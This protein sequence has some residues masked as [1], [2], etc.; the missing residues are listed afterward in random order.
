[1][2]AI[3]GKQETPPAAVPTSP[4]LAPPPD[5]VIPVKPLVPAVPMGTVT[6]FSIAGALMWKKLF[7]TVAGFGLAAGNVCA[8]A[9]EPD[10]GNPANSP[11]TRNRVFPALRGTRSAPP[12]RLTSLEEEG[13]RGSVFSVP[14]YVPPNIAPRAVAGPGRI[15]PASGQTAQPSLGVLPDV[16]AREA[17]PALPVAPPTMMPGMSV[18]NPIPSGRVDVFDPVVCPSPEEF[19]HGPAVYSS[20]WAVWGSAELLLGATRSVR[21]PPV[22]TTGPAS[23]GLFNAGALGQPGTAPLFGGQRMLGNW[24]AG[25]RSEMG[26]WLDDDHKW[27]VSGRF[28]SLFSTSDQLTGGSDGSSVVNLPQFVPVLGTTIQFPAYVGFPGITTG[29]VYASTQTNFAG[30]D[31]SLRRALMQ[32]QRFRLDVLAGYRQL[33]L[34]DEIGDHFTVVGSQVAPA[35]APTLTGDDSLR[36]RNNFFGGQL[37]GVG[38]V[39][40]KRWT[41]ETTTA[42]AL[43]VNVSDLDFS[44]TRLASVGVIGPFPLVQS[45]ISNRT[46]YFGTATEAGLKLAYRVS[47]HAKLTFGYTGLYWWNLRRAQDQFTLGPNLAG[48]TTCFSA[49]MFSWGAEFRY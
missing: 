1:M 19:V 14:P 34:G 42:V 36:T 44:R 20:R 43:G 18:Y 22:V 37:G 27:G 15:V 6:S 26:L 2:A 7:A 10:E 48:D 11:T 45:N 35:L 8:F 23:A 30:G 41:L 3:P 31:M 29:S 39:T 47:D 32:N 25:V 17:P 16:L 46:T 9:A 33:H 13:F 12:A 38:S 21:V 24:R 28:Y 40:W 4:R 5:R 49:H